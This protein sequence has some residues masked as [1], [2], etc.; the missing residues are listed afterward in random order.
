M[1]F[2]GQVAKGFIVACA[3]LAAVA[4]GAPGVASAEVKTGWIGSTGPVNG[5]LYL[6]TS[7]IDN[8][9]VPKASTRIYTAF[10]GTVAQGTMG[11][12]ARLFREGALCGATDYQFNA[13]FTNSQNAQVTKDC[14]PGWYNSHGYVAVFTPT[15]T[16]E[17]VT[18]PSDPL[19][20]A[21]PAAAT[22]GDA[23]AAGTVSGKTYGS[24]ETAGSSESL[25]DLVSAIATNGTLGYVESDELT[26]DRRAAGPR[27]VPVRSLDG[28]EV[29]TFSFNQ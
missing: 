4:F 18:F 3:G 17:F 25:P 29:G 11:S 13:F 10:G 1:R 23:R 20:Y 9:A 6:H 27:T 21:G 14:G 12:K 16:Q 7:T 26:S 24:A 2:K 8:A 28:Q 22:S 19:E 15:G 5:G